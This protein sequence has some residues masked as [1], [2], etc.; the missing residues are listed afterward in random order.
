[1]S[2]VTSVNTSG[3]GGS[4]SKL[5]GFSFNEL[6]ARVKNYFDRARAVHQLEALDDRML[7]DIGLERCDIREM[8]WSGKL[9]R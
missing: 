6:T 1:M 3:F 8:V 4:S 5:S 9:S 7:A 2:T